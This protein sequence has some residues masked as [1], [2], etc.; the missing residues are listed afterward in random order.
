MHNLKKNNLNLYL[1]YI[2][3][4]FWHHIRPF[5]PRFFTIDVFSGH[6]KET[7]QKQLKTQVDIFYENKVDHHT[8]SK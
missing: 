3:I 8:W 1:I 2:V 5:F 4:E 7:I 6:G